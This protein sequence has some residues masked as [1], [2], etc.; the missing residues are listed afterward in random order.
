[1]PCHA[2]LCC[3]AC[4]GPDQGDDGEGDGQQ[5]GGGGATDGAGP[6]PS[7]RH[8]GAAA[9]TGVGAGRPSGDGQAKLKAAG[10]QK[11]LKLKKAAAGKHGSGGGG[12]GKGGKGGKGKLGASG[13]VGKKGERGARALGDAMPRHA[14]SWAAG[15]LGG[16]AAGQWV[17]SAMARAVAVPGGAFYHERGWRGA[18][19]ARVVQGR[20]GGGSAATRPWPAGVPRWSTWGRGPCTARPLWPSLM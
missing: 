17:P 5:G 12:G 4:S 10:K 7:H 6:G 14:T 16:W 18:L 8:H 3:A 9:A 19:K 20:S 1:M 2:V 11:K 15:R 13:G